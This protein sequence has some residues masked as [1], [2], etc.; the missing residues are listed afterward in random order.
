MRLLRRWGYL[1]FIALLLGCLRLLFPGLDR[2]TNP[3]ELL[4]GSGHLPKPCPA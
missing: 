4:A 1:L 2:P 3:V